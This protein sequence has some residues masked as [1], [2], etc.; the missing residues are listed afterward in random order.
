MS[1]LARLQR[2]MFDGI[3]R[4]LT[5]R[6]LP[7][8]ASRHLLP[9]RHLGAAARL[10]V[11]NGQYWMRLLESLQEDFPGVQRLL[12]KARFE[13]LCRDYLTAHP[14][15]S[16]TLRNLGR[17]LPSFLPPG[18]ARE[19]ARFEWAKVLAFDAAGLSRPDLSQAGASTRFCLQPHL[20]L[21]DLSYEVDRGGVK[22]RRKRVF[23]AVHRQEETVYHKRL[24][25]GEFALLTALGRGKRL[26]R[27]LQA[28]PAPPERVQ[29][30]FRTWAALGWFAARPSGS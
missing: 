17:R 16:W 22:P 28:A 13:R 2:W 26:S 23:V 24:E 9:N 18:A 19:M 5:R 10:E 7:P 20:S 21:L 12:G 14:S 30:W 4:D 15:R 11:Y 1:R 8:G 6:D 25:P 27:A 29:A 3:R